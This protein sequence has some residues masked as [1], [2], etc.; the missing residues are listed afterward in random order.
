MEKSVSFLQRIAFPFFIIC[1]IWI[2]RERPVAVLV[3]QAQGMAHLMDCG[4][5]ICIR[6]CGRD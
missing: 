5:G 6:V 4:A 3:Q 2:F 1:R